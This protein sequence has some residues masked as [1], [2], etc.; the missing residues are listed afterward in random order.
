MA[1]TGLEQP[2]TGVVDN[3]GADLVLAAE[4]RLL[5]LA[6]TASTAAGGL[7]LPGM[8]DAVADLRWG[9]ENARRA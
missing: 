8:L 4:W 3:G 1:T 9:V 6:F 5:F 7:Y 2:A